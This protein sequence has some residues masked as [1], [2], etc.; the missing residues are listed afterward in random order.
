VHLDATPIEVCDPARPGKAQSATL[1]AYRARSRDPALEGLVWFDYRATKSPGHPAAVLREAEYRG[2]VQTDGAAGLD[3]LGAP[4]RVT[5]LG[6]WA[7]ARRYVEEAVQ[8]GEPGA[9]SYLRRIDRL[10]RWEAKAR[11]VAQ[12]QPA[13]ANRVESW[14]ERFSIPVMQ[15]LFAQAIADGLRVPP[16]SALG[17]ALGYLL[18]QRDSLARC[19]LTPGAYLDNNGAEN[20]IRPLKLGAKNWLFIGIRV[21]GHGWRTFSRWWRTAAK[22]GSIPKPISSIW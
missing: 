16:K 20:A 13:S 4:D 14:R 10:F 2:V 19:V 6:C 17:T 7:H 3:T 9:A 1:W 21:P 11:R 8:L 22:P 15:A 18:G 5:H 12:V